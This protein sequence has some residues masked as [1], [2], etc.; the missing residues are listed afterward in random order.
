[1]HSIPHHKFEVVV[2]LKVVPLPRNIPTYTNARTQAFSTSVYRTIN[3]PESN[4]TITTEILQG[5]T[6]YP[7]KVV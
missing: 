6:I 1:M 5:R 7:Y 3:T 2:P 4:Q